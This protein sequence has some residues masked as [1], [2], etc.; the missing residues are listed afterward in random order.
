MEF[1][2]IERFDE[3]MA[4]PKNRDRLL[5]FPRCLLAMRVRRNQKHR[6]CASISDAFV[7]IELSELDKT[8]FL[9]IRNGENLYRMNCDLEFCVRTAAD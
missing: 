2:S 1:R 7:N 6:E 8:T 4:K 3:W 5:P 9:F